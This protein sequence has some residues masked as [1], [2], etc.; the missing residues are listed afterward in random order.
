MGAGQERGNQATSAADG[1]GGGGPE[2]LDRAQ[3]G[4]RWRWTHANQKLHPWQI[5]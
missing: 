4:R 1:G 2:E 5:R 3:D